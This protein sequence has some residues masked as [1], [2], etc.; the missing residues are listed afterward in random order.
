[1]YRKAIL[2]A[3]CKKCG[4]RVDFSGRGCPECGSPFD[5]DRPSTYRNW[6]QIRFL[7]I[8]KRVVVALLIYVFLW[9]ASYLAFVDRDVK[10]FSVIS[11]SDPFGGQGFGVAEYEAK[12]RIRGEWIR[13]WFLPINSMDRIVRPAFWTFEIHPFEVPRRGEKGGPKEPARKGGNTAL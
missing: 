1:M 4:Y 3:F 13:I 2:N 7:E 6:R 8:R 9:L 11:Q 10:S 5:L 12:Y